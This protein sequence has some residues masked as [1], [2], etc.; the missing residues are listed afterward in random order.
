MSEVA[1]EQQV[2]SAK[3][4]LV[5]VTGIVKKSWGWSKFPDTLIPF[6]PLIIQ[7]DDLFLYV[8]LIGGHLIGQIPDVEE[9]DLVKIKGEVISDECVPISLGENFR[10][11]ASLG[12]RAFSLEK[13]PLKK[14]KENE[15]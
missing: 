5:Q 3:G 9:G 15:L 10:V 6:L 7:V 11:V 14:R 1:L 4:E 8:A 12:L 13:I 2:F